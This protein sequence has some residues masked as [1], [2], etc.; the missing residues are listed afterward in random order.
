MNLYD[1]LSYLEDTALLPFKKVAVKQNWIFSK[2]LVT[3]EV[4]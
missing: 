4:K 1:F 3:E 2:A